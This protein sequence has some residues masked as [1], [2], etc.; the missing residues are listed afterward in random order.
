MKILYRN[1]NPRGYAYLLNTN[2]VYV[3]G[4]PVFSRYIR[5]KY[6]RVWTM[7]PKDKNI[8]TVK[9]LEYFKRTV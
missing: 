6:K 7:N 4:K 3:N 1:N 5:K 2:C 9:I 8:K